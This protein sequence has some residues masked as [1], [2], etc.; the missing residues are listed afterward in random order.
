MEDQE[1]YSGPELYEKISEEWTK[2]ADS[3][4]STQ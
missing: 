4:K 3:Q 1:E 2:L